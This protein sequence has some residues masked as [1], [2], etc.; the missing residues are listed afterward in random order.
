MHHRKIA[1][2]ARLVAAVLCLWLAA[3]VGGV[4]LASD[5]V[6]FLPG[7]TLGLIPPD[8][9]ELSKAFSGFVHATTGSS[10]LLV[11]LPAAAYGEVKSGMTEEGL[12][13]QNI[14]VNTSEPIQI[15]GYDGVL[16]KGTQAV[17][18][19]Q[20]NKWILLLETSEATILLTAQDL[21]G[22]SLDDATV[23]AVLNSIQIREPPALEVQVANLPFAI[24]ELSGFRV[25]RT[26]AGSGVLLTKGPKD[27]VTDGSQPVLIIQRPIERPF[28]TSVFP[29]DLSAQLLRSVQTL[30]ITQVGETVERT[31]AGAEGYE[32][33]AAATDKVLEAEVV[34]GQWLRLNSGEQMHVLAILPKDG[35]EKLLP[36]LR[37]LVA[38]LSLKSL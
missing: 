3:P 18:G 22:D 33:I 21:T 38:G 23:L 19:T 16:V 14:T 12:A 5:D 15:A 8:G 25:V 1:S 37:E 32:T 6:V 10:F 2:A 20:V 11:Q 27:V 9:F 4:A 31:V 29:A 34:V 13:A 17:G 26:I 36:G 35:H 24:G 7:K 30:D 28:P